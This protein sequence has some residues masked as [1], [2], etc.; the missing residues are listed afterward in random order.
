MISAMRRRRDTPPPY[1]ALATVEYWVH[2]PLSLLPRDLGV[3]TL[4]IPDGMT[5]QTIALADLPANWLNYPAPPEL[6]MLGTQW[7]CAQETPVLRVPSTVH[8]DKN[9]GIMSH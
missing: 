3:V 7:T 9:I 5:P 2:V 8:L 4:H 6:A 1:P